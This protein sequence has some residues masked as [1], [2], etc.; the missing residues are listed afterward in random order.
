MSESKKAKKLSKAM[1]RKNSISAEKKADRKAIII[2]LCLVLFAAGY[3]CTSPRRGMLYFGGERIKGTV[4][5]YLDGEPLD[6]EG[7]TVTDVSRRPT[8]DRELSV[9]KNGNTV[10]ITDEAGEKERYAY[11]LDIPECGTVSLSVFHTDWHQVTRFGC[12]LYLTRTADGV[13]AEYTAHEKSSNMSV[14]E[15]RHEHSRSFEAGEKI[16]ITV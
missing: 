2:V 8:K 13:E 5:V 9:E 15:K 1:Q 12:E 11:E 16:N 6:M 14:F 3:V 7:V 10:S 4:S